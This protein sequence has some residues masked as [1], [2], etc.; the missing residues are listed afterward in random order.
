[1]Y[2]GLAPYSNVGNSEKSSHPLNSPQDQL[3]PILTLYHNPTSFTSCF[4]TFLFLGVNN[5]SRLLNSYM[6]ISIS[7]LASWENQSA[8]LRPIHTVIHCETGSHS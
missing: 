5:K 8:T 3:E 1:M 6:L 7:M 4:V 2:E